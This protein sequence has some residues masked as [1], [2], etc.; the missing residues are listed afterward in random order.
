[1]ISSISIIASWRCMKGL[2]ARLLGLQATRLGRIFLQ[3]IFFHFIF[4]FIFLLAFAQFSVL[5]QSLLPLACLPLTSNSCLDCSSTFVTLLQKLDLLCKYSPSDIVVLRSGSSRLRLHHDSSRYMRQLTCRVCLVDLLASR[6]GALQ[7]NMVEI[8]IGQ[9]WAR[10]HCALEDMARGCERAYHGWGFARGMPDGIGPPE[11]VRL[12]VCMVSMQCIRALQLA[13]ESRRL[14][15]FST[16]A[17]GVD[18]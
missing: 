7:V 12:H 16:D 14:S 3:L 9:G 2:A 17:K 18:I 15:R 13:R 5:P 8:G 11:Q 1:M 6:P 10:W 4:T